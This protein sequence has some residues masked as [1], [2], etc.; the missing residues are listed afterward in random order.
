MLSLDKKIAD[1]NGTDLSAFSTLQALAVKYPT[2]ATKMGIDLSKGVQGIVAQRTNLTQQNQAALEQKRRESEIASEQPTPEVR[3]FEQT[4]FGKLV[5]EKRGT[6]EY[7]AA[8]LAFRKSPYVEQQAKGNEI[9][10]NREGTN[11]RVEFYKQP[12]VKNY[13]DIRQKYDVMNEALKES[14]STKNFVATDQAIITLYNKMTDPQS[15]VRESEYARTA[16]DLALWR[17]LKGKI[18]KWQGG[19]AGLTQGDREAVFKM[20]GKFL[21]ASQTK[22]KERFKEYRGYFTAYGL[23]PEK[24]LNPA[25]DTTGEKTVIETRVTKDGRTLIKYSDGT[26]EEQQ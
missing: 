22:Y 24:F 8:F 25:K 17:K 6:P 14:R 11:L 9:A 4:Q 7:R 20:A 15:V 26:I 5:P 1:S 16:N 3:E 21:Q 2:V 23:D 12:E 18:E 19:G 10:L 13:V